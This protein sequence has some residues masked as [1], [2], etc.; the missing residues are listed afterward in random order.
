MDSMP[1]PSLAGT[2]DASEHAPILSLVLAYGA[3]VPLL[4]G[5]L[6]SWVLPAPWDAAALRATLAWAGALLCFFSGVRRG[7][8]FRQPGGATLMQVLGTLLFFGLGAA[9]LLSPW[10][11]AAAILVLA[12]YAIMLVLD[13][14]A[15]RRGEAPRY[16]ARLR[17]VQL[18]LP[19]AGVAAL[20]P[21]LLG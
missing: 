13:P 2:E 8:S 5:A 14:I 21:K 12:G 16:F 19:L 20:L 18:L 11:L 7:L 17:P 6:A 4:A 10:P 3:M 9:S 1:N 15:A